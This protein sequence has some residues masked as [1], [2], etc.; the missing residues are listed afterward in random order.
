MEL[1]RATVYYTMHEI[2]V[3]DWGRTRY[4]EALERQLARVELRKT[5]EC[6]DSL[7]FTE[8]N[9]VYTMGLRKGAD[10]HLIWNE[11]KLAEQGIEVFQI[12]RGGDITYHGPG[13]I[14][15]YPI[16]SLQSRKDLH[17][18]LRDLE[19]IVIRALR[20]FGLSADRREG[21]TGI[22]L[23][24]RKIC[25]IGVAVKSW[26]TYHGFALNVDLNMDHFNGI[27]PCGITD[28]SVTSLVNE[29]GYSIEMADLKTAL[30]VEFQKVFANSAPSNE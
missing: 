19:E 25:A 16:I 30:A 20:G 18:Y 21:K 26:V 17:T 14:V 15:G 27:V 28:G 22:W 23:E 10:Q 8:H 9:P 13:Q 2:E 29:L 7:I 5:G 11:T 24:T 4:A 6:G 12:N 3:I 1:F